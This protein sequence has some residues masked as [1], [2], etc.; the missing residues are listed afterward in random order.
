MA[1]PTLAELKARH[2]EL[3]NKKQNKTATFD[4]DV[5]PFWKMQ[6]GQEA[7]VRIL[8]DLDEENLDIF[9]IEKLS[10]TIHINNK[11]RY[12]PC[13][14]MYG[15]DCP[16]CERS[17]KY[18][19]SDDKVKGKYYWRSKKVLLRA[20]ILKDPLPLDESG[21]RVGRVMTLSLMAELTN[22]IVS[23]VAAFADDDTPPWDLQ[24]GTNF[25]I[26][27]GEKQTPTGKQATYAGSGF[28]RRPS[29]L[30]PEMLETVKLVNLRTLLPQNPGLDKVV[31]LL[32]AHDNRSE[33]TGGDAAG[34]SQSSETTDTASTNAAA[35]QS[36][37]AEPASNTTQ[38]QTVTA[39][40]TAPAANATAAAKPVG[41]GGSIL[42]KI[43]RRQAQ[44][45][46]AGE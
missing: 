21:P 34:A 43:K 14:R 13:I 42:D 4:S 30:P 35:D 29:P 41:E 2:K 40:A 19:N 27:R 31:A 46:K 6:D 22:R 38:A 23:D 17:Q 28:E 5:Y 26:R 18:Y 25:V 12:I 45:A 16:V 7:V 37:V 1:R 24:G 15:E 32:E 8:A 39:A 11:E 20:L 44:A 36:Q 10:H 3:A 33:Y 9:Q